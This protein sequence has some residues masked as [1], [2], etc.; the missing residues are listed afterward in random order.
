MIRLNLAVLAA[1]VALCA[2]PA[3]AVVLDLDSAANGQKISGTELSP[4]VSISS[5]GPNLGATIFD[6]DPMGPNMHADDQDLL[7]DVGNVLILQTVNP[8]RGQ[9]WFGLL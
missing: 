6:T 5:A 8:S 3:T 7:V 1:T 9:W 4:L 2:S